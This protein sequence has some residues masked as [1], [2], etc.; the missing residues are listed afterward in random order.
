MHLMF[1]WQEQY[2]MSECS[3]RV[4]DVVHATRTKIKFISST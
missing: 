3:E 1:E 4:R 2:L